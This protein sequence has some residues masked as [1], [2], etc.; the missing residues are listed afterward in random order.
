MDQVSM[1]ALC[2][3]LPIGI[4][5]HRFRASICDCPQDN[6]ILFMNQAFERMTGLSWT[7][8][9][10]FTLTQLYTRLFS[11]QRRW[12]DFFSELP[13]L[14][15]H[16]TIEGYCHTTKRWFRVDLYPLGQCELIT[17]FTDITEEK[18]ATT[19][20]MEAMHEELKAS[21]EQMEVMNKEL[22]DLNQELESTVHKLQASEEKLSALF[23]SMI[24]HVV[25]HELVFDKEG[26]PVNYRILG[27][28]RRFE[29]VTGITEAQAIGKLA[30][31][32][33]GTSETPY[34]EEY[35]QVVM[36]GK[37]Y[38]FET[39]FPPMDKHFS[40]SA[41]CIGEHRFATITFDITE[42]KKAEE[43]LRE[44]EEKHRRLFETMSPGVI[45]QNADGKIVSANPSAL[46]MLGLT[47]DQLFGKTSM[48][49]S[50]KMILPDGTKVEGQ[51]HPA[52]IALRTGKKIGPVTRGVYHAEKDHHIW[53]SITAIPLFEPGS[54]KPFQAYATFDDITKRLKAEEALKASEAK[55]KAVLD[56]M[57]LGVAVNSVIPEVKFEYMN[58]NFP[59]IYRTTREALSDPGSFWEVVYQDPV[60]RQQIMRRVL[61]GV[62]SDDPSKR[63]W[64]EIPLTRQG[65]ETTYISAQNIPV[66]DPSLMV[67]LVWDVTERKKMEEQLITARDAAE[68]GNRAKSQFLANISHELR[69][70]LNGVLGFA[71]LLQASPLN[72]E[73]K[74]FLG[75]IIESAK[76]LLDVIVRILDFTQIQTEAFQLHEKET[77]LAM[78]C[79]KTLE[80]VRV[81]A[82]K[83][84][85]GLSVDIAPA[86]EG[87]WMVDAERLQEV[88]LIL[89]RNA[90]KF[91]EQ[92]S[93]SLIL[94]ALDDGQV[95]D[96]R[97]IR[98]TVK[99]TGI[100]IDHASEARIFQIF[101]QADMSHTRR[102]GG[103][104]MGLPV[105]QGILKRMKTTL[106]FESQHGSG[107]SFYFDLPLSRSDRISQT[108][109]LHSSHTDE[110]EAQ[111]NDLSATEGKVKILV[112]E[113]DFLNAQLI[114]LF[115][116]KHFPNAQAI[117]AQTGEAATEQYPLVQPDMVLM[118]IQ[119]P[120]I[121]GFEAA[122]RIRDIET[123]MGR[124]VPIIAV[125]A[126][127]EEVDR[128]KCISS[129]M[130]DYLLKPLNFELAQ[131]K[132][133]KWISASLNNR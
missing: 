41:V 20:E 16:R 42:Q 21:Y 101:E 111:K 29:E 31:D 5:Y 36:S 53:L 62:A 51:D 1:E 45:Y 116:E 17:L 124:R 80:Q 71:E 7:T 99:D 129:G 60:F 83:K 48:D 9:S 40:I 63:L 6:Q 123:G 102:F 98:F 103:V 8:I 54:D 61:E 75:Y 32:V 13:S 112:V 52:M 121:D 66:P 122:R 22:T 95:F 107:S 67:S 92:G 77:D 88:L 93:V 18:H 23:Q 85:I 132:I 89:L 34:L 15:T 68:A 97:S 119:M 50:W 44:S 28:N 35:V 106:H 65:E 130:D 128:E 105:A 79:H 14:N 131:I 19:E 11:D 27:F 94:S 33:Y 87:S 96:H 70:P 91:T 46:K 76:G 84:G 78:L 12:T 115:L 10:E 86:L 59:K 24:E 114:R 3:L 64:E 49:P 57:P 69:T 127:V 100:G 58:D 39:Y 2:Q 104:G 38:H 55:L 82:E 90:V 73:Q 113:D 26:Q 47:M 30:T 126:A 81:Q 117:L 109:D 133:H 72:P 37:P 118:D 74:E 25:F 110:D 120:G 108:Q 56:H 43:K 125:T 4:T